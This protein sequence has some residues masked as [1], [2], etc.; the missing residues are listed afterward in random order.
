M[1]NDLIKI[2]NN[3]KSELNYNDN[4]YSGFELFSRLVSLA[5]AQA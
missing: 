4:Q 3:N 2:T 5:M 1:I